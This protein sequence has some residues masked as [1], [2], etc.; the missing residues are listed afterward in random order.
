MAKQALITGGGSGIGYATAKIL[1]EKGYDVVISGR[2]EKKLAVAASKISVR[3]FAA[4]LTD[5]KQIE[6]LASYMSNHGLD[7]LV[8]NA[9]CFALFPLEHCDETT[10]DRFIDTN[11][12]G[13]IFLT[14]ALLPLL[15]KAS[16]SITNVSSIITQSALPNASIYATTKG[17]IEAF[18]KNLAIELAPYNIRVNA[19]APGAVDTSLL[20][21]SGISEDK[22]KAIQEKTDQIIPL[23]R[24][25]TPQEIAHAIVSQLESTYTTG[26][27][28]VVD[29]GI[30]I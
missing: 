8:N 18:T 11:I 12:K 29:G 30:S 16:G 17:A 4:D 19:I 20:S 10:F 23:K 21:E 25:A 14:K 13:N 9:A 24:H 1:T 15:K 7:V 27:V 26:A 5:I 3:Y 2:N 28:W 6:Q 22:I